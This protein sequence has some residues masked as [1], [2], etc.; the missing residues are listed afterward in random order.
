MEVQSVGTGTSSLDILMAR[1]PIYNSENKLF[2][3]ELLFRNADGLSAEVFGGEKATSQVVVNLCTSI[4]AQFDT[5]RQP[6]FINITTDFLDS[7]S[8]LP[9]NPEGVVLEL[10]HDTV[11]TDSLL[12]KLAE[13]SHKGYRF[14]LDGHHPDKTDV[15]LFPYLDHVKLDVSQLG[16]EELEEVV[17]RLDQYTFDLIAGKVETPEEYRQCR[18]LGFSLFQGYFLA[19]PDKILGKTINPSL[20]GLM[21]VLRQVQSKTSSIEDVSEAVSR[22]PKLVYQVLRILNSPACRLQRKIDTIREALVLL[23]L[24]QLREWTMLIMLASSGEQNVELVRILLTRARACEH[25]AQVR[26]LPS[27]EQFFMA[28]MLSGIDLLLEADKKVLLDQIS[29]SP[30]V[31]A[32]LLNNE[33]AM[34]QIL[35]Q[36][37]MIEQRDWDS[38]NELPFELYQDV[39]DAYHEAGVWA[40]EMLSLIYT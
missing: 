39:F 31:V 37:G 17:S 22:E 26:D 6:L 25:F 40:H 19:R 32:A 28:G 4:N 13:L 36:I 9:I 16:A 3:Y 7:E 10:A 15:A 2:G 35:K 8:F 30:E 20:Q 38:L 1:Q 12:L 11:V 21:Q 29:V 24:N 5:F 14:A 33:G 27:P 18:E 34:G 23:G